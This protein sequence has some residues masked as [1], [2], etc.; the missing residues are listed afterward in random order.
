MEERLQKIEIENFIW[1]IYLFI[2]GFAFYSNSLEKDYFLTKNEN[3]K[4]RYRMINACIFLVLIFV[5]SYFEKDAIT[6]LQE[7]DKNNKKRNLDILSFIATSA[8]LL[9]GFLFLYIILVD[10]DL[11]EEIAFN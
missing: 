4:Q 7:Q 10:N 1:I 8:V 11:E 5:Y 6:S 3:S 2:I 9:S